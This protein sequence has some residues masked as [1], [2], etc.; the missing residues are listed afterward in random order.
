MLLLIVIKHNRYVAP[1]EVL[2]S[3]QCL[4]DSLAYKLIGD[5]C[6]D[7]IGNVRAVCN[8]YPHFSEHLGIFKAVLVRESRFNHFCHNCGIFRNIGQSADI[9]S[10]CR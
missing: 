4:F 3:L 8:T 7:R 2:R 10:V 9:Y 6:T 1:Y 5:T